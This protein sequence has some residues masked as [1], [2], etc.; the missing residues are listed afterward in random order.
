MGRMA[1]RTCCKLFQSVY[2]GKGGWL[3]KGQVYVKKRG[4]LKKDEG[5]RNKAT[6]VGFPAEGN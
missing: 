6:T 5:E 3:E 4:K 2:W 1:H